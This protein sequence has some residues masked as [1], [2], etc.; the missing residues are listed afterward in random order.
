[1]SPSLLAFV[2]AGANYLDPT[3]DHSAIA[4]AITSVVESER[5]L[6]ADDAD[7]R[8]TASLVLAVAWRE[9]SLRTRVLGDCEQKTEAG[10]C[11][12]KP[13]SFCTMQIHD[14]SGG[15]PALNDDPAKCI[16]TGL[17]MLRTSFRS[18]S[19]HPIAWYASGPSGCTN[20][21]A[22]RISRDRLAL[23]QRVFRAATDARK[24][25]A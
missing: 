15:T 21:R 23:A 7:K 13:H 16:R 11:I 2:L 10:V 18:C 1:M 25:A 17:A 8:R 12:A 6:F 22:Q 24:E 4:E 14:S 19:T 5:P 20:A 3:H 9:G